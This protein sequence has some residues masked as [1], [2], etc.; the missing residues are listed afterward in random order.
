L[1]RCRLSN[2]GAQELIKTSSSY[3]VFS[4]IFILLKSS[5]VLVY[6]LKREN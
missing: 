2:L 1:S 6:L 3:L 5:V 4:I